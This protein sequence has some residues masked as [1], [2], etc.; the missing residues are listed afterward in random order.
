MEKKPWRESAKELF[1]GTRTIVLKGTPFPSKKH[2][3]LLSNP[4]ISHTQNP[5]PN[6][7]TP[8]AERVSKGGEGTGCSWLHG[9]RGMYHLFEPLTVG[10][11]GRPKGTPQVLNAE[12]WESPAKRHTH[13][14]IVAHMLT[15]QAEG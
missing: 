7:A 11:E 1:G 12:F 14:Q 13:V 5:S 2:V 4:H 8:R 15:Q 6:S 3:L 10:F 9:S